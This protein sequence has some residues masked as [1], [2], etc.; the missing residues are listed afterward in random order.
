MPVLQTFSDPTGTGGVAHAT[1]ANNLT[2]GSKLIAIVGGDTGSTWTVTSIGDGAGHNFSQLTTFRYSVGNREGVDIWVLDNTLS[3]KPTFTTACSS[4]GNPGPML[5][6]L[7]VSGLATGTTTTA[8]YDG[9]AATR[10]WSAQ[11]SPPP[12]P[13]YSSSVAGEFLLSVIGDV[14]YSI[15]TW[16][17]PSGYTDGGGLQ[18]A[19]FGTLLPAYK[20][21]T[22]GSESAAWTWTGGGTED[23][24]AI[25][26]AFKLAGGGGTNANINPVS[27]TAT[28]TIPIPP[29]S[30][31]AITTPN[32]ISVNLTGLGHWQNITP[33]Q[34]L[35]DGNASGNNDNFGIDVVNLDPRDGSITV[36]TCYQGHFKSFDQ[37]A[38]WVKWN[39]GTG[40]SLIDSGKSWTIARDFY[41]PNLMFSN[42][43]NGGGGPLKSVDNGVSWTT[44]YAGGVAQY[45]N[46]YVIVCDPY[47][48]NHV[49][50]T[51][52]D[53]WSIDNSNSG[54]AESFDAGVTWS[55]HNPGTSPA[56]GTGNAC[57]FLNNSSS[58]FIG[59]QSGG[60][61]KT[62]NSGTSWTT[63]SSFNMT[64]GG[65]YHTTFCPLD[66]A[67]YTAMDGQG[68]WRSTD[69]CS[70]F[71]QIPGNIG[72]GSGWQ[73]AAFDGQNY[74]TMPGFP[75][76]N[77]SYAIVPWSYFIP[78][79]NAF[80][81]AYGSQVISNPGNPPS[82]GAVTNGPVSSAYDPVRKTVYTANWQAGVW[83]LTRP[84]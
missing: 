76:G 11:A 70:T 62:I 73:N 55:F 38:T 48:A 24:G 82:A 10:S 84:L 35:S 14:Q 31:N 34:W 43:Q 58:W 18:S 57:C 6:I 44:A 46:P 66:G 65:L 67:W 52:H 33:P 16:V 1:P 51:Y 3:T 41:N 19:T 40:G 54:I 17:M 79:P 56:W 63:I 74:Y 21:S 29:V 53:P 39:T 23:G 4:A 49:L 37:G 5:V 69:N 47:L 83:K 2:P 20:N 81:Q 26:V 12:Q 77:T 7:E 60:F 8:C 42:A 61:Y 36:A 78:G 64:H 72:V 75:M 25:L 71:T 32:I 50:A 13:T 27:I 59:C 15:T 45:N 80:L 22:G 28:T 9:A 30:A 68:I